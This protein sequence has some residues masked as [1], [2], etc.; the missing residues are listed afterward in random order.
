MDLASLRNEY[1]RASLD[2]ADVDP[3]PFRQFAAWLDAAV[4]ARVPEPNAMTLATVGADGKPSSRIVLL[5]D[6]DAGG[7]T[8]YTNFRSRKGRELD[9]H[10]HAAIVFFWPELERQVRI[11]GTAARAD[12]ARADAYFSQR[13]R[14]S[15]LGAW[16][17]PQS[18]PIPDRAWL[19]RA[20]D[21][22]SQRFA[23]AGDDVPRPP[24]WGGYTLAPVAFEFWQGRRSRLHDR[25]VYRRAGDAWTIG[26]LAP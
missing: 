19:D 4:V 11:E 10:P 18:E 21:G 26:R 25:I 24:H 6:V 9:A 23:T 12:A 20:W 16:A 15:R 3:D 7:L 1:M 2:A 14:T 13:P 22:A 5:R 17:S 8:F